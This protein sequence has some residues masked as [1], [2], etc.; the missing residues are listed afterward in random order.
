MAFTMP[1]SCHEGRDLQE[2]NLSMVDG[3]EVVVCVLLP[4]P[5][6]EEKVS[7]TKARSL[8]GLGSW[9]DARGGRT[10]SR[11]VDVQ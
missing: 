5:Y 6:C 7:H 4:K 1:P 3:R 10:Q 2:G 11:A 9:K 8:K